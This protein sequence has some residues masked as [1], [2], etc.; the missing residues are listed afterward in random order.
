MLFKRESLLSFERRGR[1]VVLALRAPPDGDGAQIDVE[2]L[3][4]DLGAAVAGL[5]ASD[6]VFDF[7]C[8]RWVGSGFLGAA[9]TLHRHSRDHGGRVAFVSGPEVREVLD[10]CRFGHVLFLAGSLAEAA[11]LLLDPAARPGRP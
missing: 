2:R 5:G 1:A 7:S 4:D 11:A 6:I 3:R 8:L 9:L 10:I